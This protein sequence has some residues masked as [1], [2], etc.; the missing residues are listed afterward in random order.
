M[1]F[2]VARAR[3]AGPGWPS[4]HREQV[5]D[6]E[7]AE[8]N[9]PGGR[10]PSGRLW[11]FAAAMAI[12]AAAIFG[13]GLASRPGVAEAPMQLPWYLIAVAVFLVELFVLDLHIRGEAHSFSVSEIVVVVGF[14]FLSP[15]ALLAAVMTG[16]L[17][18][19]LWQ[20]SP[21]VKLVYNLTQ[22]ALGTGAALWI[23]GALYAADAPLS[24]RSW[25]GALAASVAT[26]VITIVAISLAVVQY[27]G[28]LPASAVAQ[29]FLFS[30]GSAV[31]NTMLGLVA[32]SLL[33]HEP[34]TVVL[35][36]GPITVCIV[37]YRAYHSERSKTAG[38]E[39][40]YG[41][42]QVLNEAPDLEGGLVALLD[43]AR[44]ALHAEYAQVVLNGTPADGNVFLTAVGPGDHAR[45]IELA[46]ADLVAPVFTALGATP[47]PVVLRGEAAVG[48]AAE[49]F[50]IE[51]AMVAPLGGESDLQGAVLVA[52]GRGSVRRFEKDDLHLFE[53]FASHLAVTLEKSQLSKSLEQ[54]RTLKNEL[55]HQA[56]HDSLTGLANRKMFRERVD[57]A[58]VENARTGSRIAVL[59]I[60]LDDFKT[61]N[62]TMGHAAGDALLEEVARRIAGSIGANGTAARLGGDEFAVLLRNVASD[63]VAR[64][65]ADRILVALGDPIDVGGHPVITHASIGI[66]SHVGAVDAS[67]LMQNADVA[68]YTAKRNGK[69]RFDE[70]EPTMRLS[71]ARRHQL[72]LGLERALAAN[73]FLLH[74][75]PVID[76]ATGAVVATEALLRWQDPQRGLLPP[77]EFVGV[78]EET[79]LIVSIGR[80][81]LREACRQ[82][83]EWAVDAPNV[84]MFVNLSTCQLADP[85]IIE[86]V[87]NAL[88]DAGLEPNHLL[89]EVTETA[90]M[91][92]IDEAKETLEALKT[93]GVGIAIDDF[94][95][96]FSSLSYLRQLPIDTLKIAKPI[97]DAICESKADAGFVKGIIDL[98]HVVGIDVVAEGVEQVEQYAQ[99]VDMGCDYVQG[100]Y[101]SPSM[102]PGAIATLL[103]TGQSVP[104]P[105]HDDFVH[106]AR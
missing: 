19:M 61:V 91:R 77:S 103:A 13:L 100:Y 23:F 104:Q 78:A 16:T 93:L 18:A 54:L 5:M 21:L 33:W 25:V 106:T 20:R 46:S 96:G 66:A 15:I 34:W 8:V 36:T 29:S 1:R 22:L 105:A 48:L 52:N 90:M 53:T 76:A 81:V 7:G 101:H 41:A 42:T 51:A 55:A 39:F 10:R 49:D 83:A 63:S 59:F 45:R 97:I 37:A 6:E 9:A 50:A 95:T 40:L 80:F 27:A 56:F 67:E 87:C 24:W 47:R 73:E 99:L 82:A 26:G 69:G 30:M 31:V 74:Y 43:F 68:M 35:L 65:V 85:D 17:A 2:R 32:V 57:E 88:E 28:R 4:E 75:Q 3:Q 94:G 92:D 64:T 14:F 86:D 102:E 38:L 44:D 98:G 84:R 70:F 60:D 72:K 71:V 89:L 11:L 62:D 79:G 58:L 12:A